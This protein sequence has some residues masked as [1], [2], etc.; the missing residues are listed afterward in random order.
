L[1]CRPSNKYILSK[2]LIPPTFMYLQTQWV[3]QESFCT[4][5]FVFFLCK[6]CS[7]QVITY[8]N[9][10]IMQPCHMHGAF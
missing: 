7:I 4:N 8:A 9:S 3:S 6:R 2:R 5:L 1:K 10:L